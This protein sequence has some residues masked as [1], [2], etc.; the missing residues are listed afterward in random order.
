MTKSEHYL[1]K[2]RSRPK[3]TKGTM[4]WVLEDD[5]YKP[6]SGS[7]LPDVLGTSSSVA[8]SVLESLALARRISV[9]KI[10]KILK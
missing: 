2:H 7:C 8:S 6:V 3:F 5:L 4:S 1:V 9:A 10:I